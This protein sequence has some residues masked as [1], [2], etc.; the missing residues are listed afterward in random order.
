MLKYLISAAVATA[1]TASASAIA[2]DATPGGLSG[3]IDTP[4]AVNELTVTGSIDARDLFFIA[5][6][7]TALT[8]LDL[9]AANIAAYE[10]PAVRQ[11]VRYDENQIPAGTFAGCRLE[12]VKFGAVSA[13]RPAL[14]IGQAAFAGSGLKSIDIPAG[15]IVDAGAFA[16]CR[17][18]SSAT[19]SSP[20]PDGC[21]S[22]CSALATASIGNTATVGMAA[23]KDCAALSSVRGVSALKSIGNDAF[24]G[25]GSLTSMT[26]PASLTGLGNSAFAMSGLTAADLSACRQLGAIGD[27]AFTGCAALKEVRLPQSIST[28]GEGSFFDC[29]S[30][31]SVSMPS[32]CPILSAYSFKGTSADASALIK[33]GTAE[34][35]DYALSGNTATTSVALPES[36]EY[37]GDHAMAGMSSLSDINGESLTAVPA[38][39]NDVWAGIDQPTVKLQVLDA[40][41]NDFAT[42]D[43]WKNFTIT[44]TTSDE[45]IVLVPNHRLRG[46][47]EG[48]VLKV[49]FD[50]LDVRS[51]SVYDVAGSRIAFIEA[52]GDT[53]ASIDTSDRQDRIYLV[54]A[55][56]A[57][58]NTVSLKLARN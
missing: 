25:C 38:L 47:F 11:N 21:F 23:F 43:Q 26:F 35:G 51:L 54:S 8:S 2:I 30:L 37:L 4:D 31:S 40:M 56:L 12:N 7:M 28:L 6:E 14:V 18:L 42:A 41:Y 48:Q 24:A 57:D 17:Q 29:S 15:Y 49:N 16:G 34:I 36:L 9:S 55:I 1:A 19:M 58:G 32:A 5:D 53:S 22:G 52:D 45:S 46:R 10:G 20:V 39:G 33:E 44:Y 50:G 13:S 3:L 27:W